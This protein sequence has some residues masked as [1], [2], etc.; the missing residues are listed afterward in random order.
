MKALFKILRKSN[1]HCVALLEFFSSAWC[2]IR[3]MCWTLH[4][5]NLNNINVLLFIQEAS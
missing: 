4:L 2:E 1:S 3:R 5:V